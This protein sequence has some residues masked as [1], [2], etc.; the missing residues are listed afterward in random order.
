[1]VKASFLVVFW[2]KEG[3]FALDRWKDPQSISYGSKTAEDGRLGKPV[4]APGLE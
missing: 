4:V 2:R 3:N 1:M